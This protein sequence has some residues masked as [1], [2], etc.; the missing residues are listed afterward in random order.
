MTE[1]QGAV[2]LE[3]EARK[4]VALYLRLAQVSARG[5]EYARRDASLALAA[6]SAWDAGDRAFAERCH[7]RLAE[8]SS[9]HPLARATSFADA[10][11]LPE[12]EEYLRDLAHQ[13]PVEKVQYLLGRLEITGAC[14]PDELDDLIKLRAETDDR[15]RS[16]GRL[17]KRGERR[18]VRKRRRPGDD[19][20]PTPFTW[21][22]T[23]RHSWLR[24]GMLLML[25]VGLLAGF[26]LG[27]GFAADVGQKLMEM[28][29][30]MQP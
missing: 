7:D 18:R 27:I 23:S 6:R 11:A 21:P 28:I 9:E 20:E 4:N 12:A 30:S 2:D 8:L 26:A 29:R 22:E 5:E 16:P 25:A 3:R 13:Y 10:L 14:G 19:F 24:P 1:D 15:D 17:L